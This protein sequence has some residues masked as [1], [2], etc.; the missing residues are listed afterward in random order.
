M[1]ARGVNERIRLGYSGQAQG[2]D[3]AKEREG[4]GML[5]CDHGQRVLGGGGGAASETVVSGHNGAAPYTLHVSS[6]NPTGLRTNAQWGGIADTQFIWTVTAAQG[7]GVEFYVG[8]T[9]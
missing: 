7:V 6:N 2:Y 3:E 4:G 9:E 1:V 8:R 5:A